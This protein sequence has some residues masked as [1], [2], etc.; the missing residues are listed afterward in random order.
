MTTPP[1]VG[2]AGPVIAELAKRGQTI[3]V[4]ESL[5]GGGVCSSLVAIAGASQVVVGGVV[6]YQSSVKTHLLGV[7]SQELSTLGAVT[8]QVALAMARGVRGALGPTSTDWGLA[9]TGVAGPDPDPV[10]GAPAG[11]VFIAL[12]G[13]DGREWSTR[14]GLVGTRDEIRQATVAFA[15]GL[16]EQALGVGD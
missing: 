10:S 15:L 5:T 7:D 4:A 6:A 11:I 14:L 2:H 12:V 3:G 9:T 16:C 13:P 1:Q 8:E